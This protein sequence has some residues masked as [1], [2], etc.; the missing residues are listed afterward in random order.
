MAEAAKD[1]AERKVPA[2][3]KELLL[4][5]VTYDDWENQTASENAFY[6][7][8]YT[9]FRK[10]I[11]EMIPMNITACGPMI[12]RAKKILAERTEWQNRGFDWATR[13]ATT[14][15]TYG[16]SND[17]RRPLRFHKA[18][19][20]IVVFEA[21]AERYMQEKSP[22][23]FGPLDVYGHLRVEAAVSYV[24]NLK[25][26][27]EEIR[28]RD[29][30]FFDK[31]IAATGQEDLEV[32][33]D[34]ANGVT[35]THKLAEAVHLFVRSTY[36]DVPIGAVSFKFNPLITYEPSKHENLK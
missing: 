22:P 33:S 16:V 11:L 13:L 20:A 23:S 8:G 17:K 1:G 30:Q 36:P 26:A 3:F 18:V 35:V 32:F 31:L 21:I 27:M 7:R 9:W 5:D 6:I 15:I 29:S 25:T 2:H 34:M 19:E 28:S 12:P 14:Q 24:N 10:N 4:H